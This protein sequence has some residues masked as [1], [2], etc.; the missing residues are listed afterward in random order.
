MCYDERRT[1]NQIK[2]SKLLKIFTKND[3]TALKS[4]LKLLHHYDVMKLK[5]RYKKHCHAC[6]DT[7]KG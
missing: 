4:Q 7:A 1:E 2:A 3:Y 5:K 6:H